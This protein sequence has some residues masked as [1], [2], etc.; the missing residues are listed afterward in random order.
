MLPDHE[1]KV[2][3]WTKQ[4]RQ[5]VIL[6]SAFGEFIAGLAPWDW[7]VTMTFRNEVVPDQGVAR[8][9]EYLADLQRSTGKPVGWVLAEEFG[10][11]GGRF[12]CHLL[13]TGVRRLRRRFWWSECFR[14][15]GR[16]SIELFDRNR[17]AAFYTAKYA[18]KALGQI[19]FGGTL[20]GTDLSL[21]ELSGNPGG[22]QDTVRSDEVPRALFRIGL[23]RWHR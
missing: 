16:T 5:R 22:G 7:W 13:I 20:K 2:E 10:G 11:W 14:R 21:V 18:A 6:P 12:H 1:R 9:R 4:R 15:F 19:H 8:I 17:G 23:G 3:C